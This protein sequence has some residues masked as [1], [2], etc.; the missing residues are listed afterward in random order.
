MNIK[1]TTTHGE[2][3]L[4]STYPYEKNQVVMTLEG[5][6]TS[7]PTRESIHVGNGI[8]IHDSYGQFMNHSFTPTTKISG[9]NVIAINNIPI[10]TELTFNYNIS[11]MN[12]ACPFEVDGQ[13]VCGKQ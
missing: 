4:F 7:V 11:E 6:T 13:L 12:M 1:R 8:H 2:Y 3:G 5:Y 9:R 10:D